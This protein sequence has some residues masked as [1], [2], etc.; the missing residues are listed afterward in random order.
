MK[1][2]RKIKGCSGHMTECQKCKTTLAKGQGEFQL[3][4]S[5]KNKKFQI[6]APK[7][8]QIKYSGSNPIEKAEEEN[9]GMTEEIDE[10]KGLQRKGT[11]FIF[12]IFIIF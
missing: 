9:A 3:L 7:S 6:Q 11:I 12:F 4:Y 2:G 10:F 5:K 1:G 8:K